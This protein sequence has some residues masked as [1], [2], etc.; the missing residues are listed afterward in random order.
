LPTPQTERGDD[1]EEVDNAE[2]LQADLNMVSPVQR[3]PNS[4]LINF[5][6]GDF[7]S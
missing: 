5:D 2:Y 6:S 3:Y 7:A 1:K 4:V